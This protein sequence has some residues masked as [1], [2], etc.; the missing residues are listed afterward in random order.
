MRDKID[1]RKFVKAGAVTAG[2]MLLGA[3]YATGMFGRKPDE[4]GV[5]VIGTGDRGTGI[6]HLIGELEGVKVTACSDLIPFRLE[7][8]CQKAQVKKSYEDYR[9]LLEDKSVD[10]VVITTPFSTHGEIAI[11]ALA[12]GKHVYCEKTMVK[13]VSETQAVIDAAKRTGLVFQTGHQYHSSPLYNR[14]REIIQSGYIGEVT[15]YECQWN[16][17]GDWRRPVPD[18]KWERLINWRMYREFSG[19][20]PAELMSHQ[21]DFVNWVSESHPD[22]ITGFGGID[23]WKDGRETFDNAHVLFR[24]PSGLN[25]SFTCTTTNGYEDY[26]I[27]VLGSEATLILDYTAGKIYH[28]KRGGKATGVV[29][30]VSGAT[31]QAWQEGKGAPIDAPGNDPTIDALRQFHKSIV[32]GDAVISDIQTG[33]TTAKCVQIVLDALHEGGVRQ[34]SDYPELNFK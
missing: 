16:R 19:G 21:I 31:I 9:D 28:E 26:R 4:V 14:A 17:N 22:K 27:K 6:I 3:N 13:G 24:Y 5:G 29:D 10:A 18:L 34:W 20:L 2:G 32:D 25:A 8:A 33:A 12:A 11:A 30:G 15:A 7:A 1:R 23:H